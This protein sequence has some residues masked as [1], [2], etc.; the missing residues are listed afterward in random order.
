[1]N[2]QIKELFSTAQI[3][4]RIKALAEEISRAYNERDLIIFSAH[5][6][7]FV[8]LADLL[9]ALDIHPRTTFLRYAHNS[10]GG[11]QDLSFTTMIDVSKKDVL[12][13]TGVLETGVTQDYLQRQLIGRGAKSVKLCV[14]LNKTE[15]RH[16]ELQ[17]DWSAFETN[18]DYVF[19]Y[20]L[21]FQDRWRELP[22]LATFE[23]KE[24]DGAS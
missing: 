20:G 9:R 1:M 14:L 19:G 4:E 10:L 24:D 11:V 16:V 7:S 18:E 3:T 23:S 13:V 12:L 5:E 21:E 15:S 22:F 2:E 17:P 8:F 6:D